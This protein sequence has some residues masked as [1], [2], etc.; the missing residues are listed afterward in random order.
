M[1]AKFNTQRGMRNT[2]LKQFMLHVNANFLRG[3]NGHFKNLF[4]WGMHASDKENKNVPFYSIRDMTSLT[5]ETDLKSRFRRETRS[6]IPDY[7]I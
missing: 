5:S 4:A 2:A 3:F 7:L 1:H 6:I